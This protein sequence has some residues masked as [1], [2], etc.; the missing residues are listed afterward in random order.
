MLGDKIAN[1][2]AD[3]A[4]TSTLSR[5]IRSSGGMQKWSAATTGPEVLNV[6]TL[7]IVAGRGA[8]VIL[9]RCGSVGS[10]THQ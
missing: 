3:L 5:S 6:R 8:V 9:A 1:I 10:V 2:S 4:T 7:A